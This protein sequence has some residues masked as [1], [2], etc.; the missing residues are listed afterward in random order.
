VRE[1]LRSKV[2]TLS[3]SAELIR[4]DRNAGH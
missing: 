3:P 2:G 1:M 4:E